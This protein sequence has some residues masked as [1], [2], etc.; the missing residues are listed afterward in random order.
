MYK[1]IITTLL[2]LPCVA[3][4]ESTTVFAV[5][6]Y[7]MGDNDSRAD[8]RKLAFLGAKK[9]L[10]EKSGTLIVANTKVSDGVLEKDEVE[11]FSAAILKVE[12]DDEST[13]FNGTNLVISIKVKSEVDFENVQRELEKIYSN[14]KLKEKAINQGK[15]I[16]L[17]RH[18]IF[19]LQ[20]RLKSRLPQEKV[21]ELR[22]ERKA[23]FDEIDKLEALHSS[24]L[25]KMKNRQDAAQ[26]EDQKKAR[27]IKK[28]IQYS[29]IG[30]SKDELSQVVKAIS[31]GDIFEAKS[32]DFAVTFFLD[33][34]YKGNEYPISQYYYYGGQYHVSQKKFSYNGSLLFAFDT[35]GELA[36]IFAKARYT[37]DYAII[38]TSYGDI[39][40]SKCIETKGMSLVE[41]PGGAC[42]DPTDNKDILQFVG[43]ID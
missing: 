19:V 33:A 4:A 9:R 32:R 3:Y 41:S 5:Y 7:T 14:K 20:E 18:E 27:I 35:R 25:Q 2:L 36:Y 8:A 39:Y 28:I 26:R 23:K 1:L 13:T 17:L 6:D 24:L 43:A 31:G 12:L 29:E 38:K 30:F 21:I 40:N 22:K 10:L 37:N 11:S 34:T 16:D 15:Q 42:V